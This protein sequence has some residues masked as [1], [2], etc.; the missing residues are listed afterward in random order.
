MFIFNVLLTCEFCS[1]KSQFA[2]CQC[3]CIINVLLCIINVFSPEKGG[4]P[5]GKVSIS[6]K[7]YNC[8]NSILFLYLTF[9]C[10]ND[11]V[12]I[13]VSLSDTTLYPS[14]RSS[15][16]IFSLLSCNKQKKNGYI[17]KFTKNDPCKTWVKIS[18]VMPH[19][20]NPF[21]REREGS[22]TA[23]SPNL[24]LTVHI[25]FFIFGDLQAKFFKFRFC[26]LAKFPANYTN[27]A[28]FAPKIP[29]I[30]QN[31]H[32]LPTIHYTFRCLTIGREL[33]EISANQAKF[34]PFAHKSCE[35]CEICTIYSFTSSSLVSD[36]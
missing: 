3:L 30:M 14:S 9:L 5:Y 27:S 31:L 16:C 15:L 17:N 22:L 1:P 11:L 32:R 34:T 10:H 6:P 2:K 23:K 21:L 18:K 4:K 26:L 33:S 24:C 7:A 25:C 13:D 35:L 19:P 28:Q 20:N 12:F 36:L 8:S 29:R